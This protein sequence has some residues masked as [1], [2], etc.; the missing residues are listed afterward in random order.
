MR[1]YLMSILGLLFLETSA[2]KKIAEQYMGWTGNDIELKSFTDKGKQE[3]GHLLVQSDSVKACIL[4]A[5]G[6]WRNTVTLPLKRNEKVIGG[7]FH[8]NVVY[9]FLD[10][11]NESGL[12]IWTLDSTSDV[13]TDNVIPFASKKEKVIDGTSCGD[14]FLYFTSNKKTQEFTIYDFK[15]EKNFTTVRYKFSGELWDELTELSGFS[16]TLNLQKID[17]EGEGDADVTECHNKLY[18]QDD[19]VYLIMNKAKGISKVLRFDLAHQTVDAQTI[20][21]TDGTHITIGEDAYVDNS[22]LLKDKLYYV[23]ATAASMG[24]QVHAFPSGELIKSFA[25]AKDSDIWFKNTPVIQEG[26]GTVYSSHI[27]KELGR[28]SQLIRKMLNGSALIM[29]NFNDS[30]QVEL[31][32]G[33]YKKMTTPAMGG[34]MWMGAGAG[35]VMYYANVGGFYGGS[36]WT[37]SA[38]FKMLLSADKAEHLSGEMMP[39]INERIEAYK[40]NIKIPSRAETLLKYQGKYTY[41]YYDR[42]KHLLTVVQF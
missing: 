11:G 17:F 31:A 41:S 39:S 4:H 28:T 12:H 13:A 35:A 25:T 22:Y 33:S 6:S 38:R 36:S 19:I 15:D 30:G 34:G 26:G 32:V 23:Y 10:N 1:I 18:V 2:Q 16:R 24:I 27:T 29:A 14:H 21:H 8:N 42:K 5:D 3:M 40:Q 20:S 7:F 9:C 37:K